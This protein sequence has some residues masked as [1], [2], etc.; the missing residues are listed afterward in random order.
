MH[1]R[2]INTDFLLII[3]KKLLKQRPDLKVKTFF[4]LT[5]H[6]QRSAYVFNDQTCCYLLLLGY[7]DVS[8]P[9]CEPIFGL[10]S[11]GCGSICGGG[12]WQRGPSCT[13]RSARN[14]GLFLHSSLHP[15]Y[16]AIFRILSLLTSADLTRYCCRS[17]CFLCLI[18]FFYTK[19]SFSRTHVPR[20]QLLPGGRLP[21]HQ[22]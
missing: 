20:D 5:H 1:E 13:P 15:R 2:D 9:E 11:S 10:F 7:S 17:I 4:F 3:L 16:T 14:D 8:H 19:Y 6:F 22:L 12:G 18:L 21:S